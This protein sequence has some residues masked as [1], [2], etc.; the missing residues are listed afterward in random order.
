MDNLIVLFGVV[1]ALLIIV[2][3]YLLI[4]DRKKTK[5][6]PQDTALRPGQQYW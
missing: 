2:G 1:I 5:S 3:T 6:R 4:E